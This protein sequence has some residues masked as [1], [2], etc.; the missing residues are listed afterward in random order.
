MCVFHDQF[1]ARLEIHRDCR[2]WDSGADDPTA[3]DNVH[4]HRR[5]LHVKTR[6]PRLCFSDV[7]RSKLF[8]RELR[9]VLGGVHGLLARPLPHSLSGVRLL[10]I[11][12]RLAFGRGK[13]W[14]HVERSLR[15]LFWALGLH[16]H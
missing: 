2:H 4:F 10:H 14:T 5:E 16:F 12:G 1:L 3:D 7:S 11:A 13:L 9:H 15:R 6:S 8:G